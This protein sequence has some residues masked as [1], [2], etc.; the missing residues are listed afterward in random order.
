MEI[1]FD[2]RGIPLRQRAAAV[3]LVLLFAGPAAAERLDHIVAAVNG[4]V[5]TASELAQ[6]VALNERLGRPG[7]DRAVLETETLDGLIV[8][9]LLVQEARRLKFVE[10]TNQEAAAAAAA[11][12][13]R[14]G[15][16]ESATAFLR[17]LD[18]SDAE[19]GRMVGE[20]LLVEKFVEKKVG[21]FVR[22][23][24]DEAERYFEDHAA[25]FRGKRFA[26]VQKAVTALLTD[27]K[28]GQQLD[29][30]VAEL[31]SRAD[32]RRNPR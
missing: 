11:L 10:V 5:I 27:R 4:E 18:L 9:R 31:R 25:E 2:R 29:Q 6:T 32:I 28:V 7:R 13:A 19:L 22:V 15:S 12:R 3:L 1:A 14:F 8:R 20:Q 21:L 16:E 30:Y 17:S 23:S 24:R 26:E